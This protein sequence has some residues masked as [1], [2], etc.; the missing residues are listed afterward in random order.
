M[1]TIP[2]IYRWLKMHWEIVSF[3]ILALFIELL[4]FAD[5]LH[6][7]LFAEV[8]FITAKYVLKF[9]AHR[10]AQLDFAMSCFSI[11]FFI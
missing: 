3:D 6:Y 1:P 10:R 5:Y 8:D 2:F 9:P 7:H 4:S 11:N